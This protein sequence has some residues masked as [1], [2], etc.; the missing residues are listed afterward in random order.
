MMKRKMAIIL[1]GGFVNVKLKQR[2]RKFPDANDI[3][4]ECQR[5]LHLDECADLELLRIF[6]YDAPPLQKAI[7][8]PIDGSVRDLGKSPRA[9]EAQKLHEGLELLPN[10]ALRRGELIMNGWRLGDAYTRETQKN[11]RAP[12]ANDFVPD[13]RQKGVDLRIGLDIAWLS[14]KHLVDVIVVVAGDGDLIPS[15]KLARKEGVRIYLDHLGHPVSREL[16]VHADMVL[17]A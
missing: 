17:P 11:N 3:N 14:L 4:T 6:F 9:T 2:N 12:T 10:F 8:N 7:T 1:D 15:F 13:I 16:K 5:I